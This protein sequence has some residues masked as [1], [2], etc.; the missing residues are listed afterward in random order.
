M[1][2]DMAVFKQEQTIGGK[3]FEYFFASAIE[4]HYLCR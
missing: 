1:N 2:L 3:I 4:Y